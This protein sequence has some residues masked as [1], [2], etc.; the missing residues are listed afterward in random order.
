MMLLFITTTSCTAQKKC[1]GL[2]QA[3]FARLLTKNDY[4]GVYMQG[5]NA[6]PCLISLIDLNRMS[7]VGII[8]PKL[9][10]I[11][12]FILNNYRG[13][14]AA[15]LIELTL[16]TDSLL[17]DS[18][19]DWKG[20]INPYKI[21]NYC[22]IVKNEQKKTILEPLSYSDIK[23]VKELYMKW[24]ETNKDKS[25]SELRKEWKQGKHVLDENKYKW[26]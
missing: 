18:I 2:F 16:S 15:Y 22:V 12:P 11:P 4:K 1:N 14:D 8:D 10:Y 21:Y 7:M 17:S 9:S 5:K 23:A 6:I 13:I 20:G 26:I 24:W 25:L 3:I 19:A